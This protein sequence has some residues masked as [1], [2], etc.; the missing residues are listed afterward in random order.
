MIATSPPITT[1]VAIAAKRQ[2]PVSFIAVNIIILLI[3]LL[4]IQARLD[5]SLTLPNLALLGTHKKFHR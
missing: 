2:R 5:P 4:S 1:T 3:Q